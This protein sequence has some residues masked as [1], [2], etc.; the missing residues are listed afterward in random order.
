MRVLLLLS[1]LACG[2]P[3]HFPE[4]RWE[5]APPAPKPPPPPVVEEAPKPPAMT[6]RR[7]PAPAEIARRIENRIERKL[8]A[9]SK[10]SRPTRCPSDLSISVSRTLDGRFPAQTIPGR[11]ASQHL[12][13]VRRDEL[14]DDETAIKRVL[15]IET[16]QPVVVPSGFRDDMVALGRDAEFRLLMARCELADP[17][18]HR[19]AGYDAAMA[20][21]LGA[22]PDVVLPLLHKSMNPDGTRAPSCRIDAD[23]SYACD[24]VTKRC[25]TQRGHVAG[26]LS[27]AELEIEDIL[28]RAVANKLT[29]DQL[30][31]RFVPDDVIAPW[32]FGRYTRCGEAMCRISV[33]SVN[34]KPRLVYRDRRQPA[35]APADPEPWQ[36]CYRETRSVSRAGCTAQ[37]DAVDA[38]WKRPCT[39]TCA[40]SC[41]E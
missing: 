17:Y 21:L 27:R 41:S 7:A 18:T 39:E 33:A 3:A 10:T 31:R 40:A 22:S 30:E 38:V 16:A 29:P 15:A 6:M 32:L 9:L 12:Q 25:S 14:L 19:R 26:M 8:D 24:A 1:I 20:L 36:V 35:E 34:G 28:V 2:Q 4:T 37:C 11:L 13:P 23:C 5:S